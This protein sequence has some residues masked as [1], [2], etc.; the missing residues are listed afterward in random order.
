MP[1]IMVLASS[2]ESSLWSHVLFNCYI[3]LVFNLE[4]FLSLSLF[5]NTDDFEE[6]IPL[7]L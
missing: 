5:Y 3:Y 7:P 4:Q 6:W 1:H 2:V